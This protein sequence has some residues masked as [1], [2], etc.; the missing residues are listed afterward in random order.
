MTAFQFLGPTTSGGPI[1]A[2]DPPSDDEIM[3]ALET[4][5]PVQG[6]IPMLWEKQRNNVRI[7]KEKIAD[8]MDPP[9]FY[10]TDRPGTTAPRPLQVHDL[11][12]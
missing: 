1:V 4:A 9:R 7:I 10:P 12:R 11:L 6:G 3:H 2:L 5:R 8:Y